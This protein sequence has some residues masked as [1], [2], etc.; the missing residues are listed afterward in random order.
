MFQWIVLAIFLPTLA[1]A[2]D[3]TLTIDGRTE[4]GV[5]G[6]DSGYYQGSRGRYRSRHAGVDATAAALGVI[7][8]G[9]LSLFFLESVEDVRRLRWPQSQVNAPPPVRA[10]FPQ[11][12]SGAV[13]H[14][15]PP[16]LAPA[17]R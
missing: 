3:A 15:S 14:R 2:G 8:G 7:G 10:R 5:V 9:A 6:G 17:R 16:L 13:R 1:M 12:P 11:L 4:F